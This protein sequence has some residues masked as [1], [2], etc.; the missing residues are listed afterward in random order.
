MIK[1]AL[2]RLKIRKKTGNSLFRQ[3]A[4]AVILS[5]LLIKNNGVTKNNNTFKS[6]KFLLLN[7]YYILTNKSF[8]NI[9]EQESENFLKR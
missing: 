6:E 5:R 8:I 1:E 9:I 3:K 2:N 4:T 7:N